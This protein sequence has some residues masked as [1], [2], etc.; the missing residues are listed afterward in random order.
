MEAVRPT[1]DRWLLEFIS[2]H[3][4]TARDFLEVREG[5]VRVTSQLTPAVAETAPLWAKAVAPV[6]EKVAQD[7][8]RWWR[9]RDR[10]QP[11]TARAKL[12]TPL[13]QASRS[14]G[15]P[16]SNG[17]AKAPEAPNVERVRKCRECGDPLPPGKAVVCP[18]ACHDQHTREVSLPKFNAAGPAKLAQ[19]RAEGV[20]PSGTPEALDKLSRTKTNSDFL[21]SMQSQ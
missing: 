8:Y 16:T 13:T 10:K 12:P 1:V 3:T 9:G 5:V 18:G 15:R 19:L 6:A 4:F 2:L 11:T 21:D 20:N 14:A 17:V 7:F